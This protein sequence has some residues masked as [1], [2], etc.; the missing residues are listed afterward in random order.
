MTARIVL[1]VALFAIAMD[2]RGADVPAGCVPADIGMSSRDCLF[3]ALQLATRNQQLSDDISA[4]YWAYQESLHSSPLWYNNGSPARRAHLRALAR[5][6]MVHYRM[7][8]MREMMAGHLSHSDYVR[9]VTLFWAL[10]V[11]LQ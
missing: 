7:D 10:M 5:H 3:R 6:R 11:E 9:S 1:A 2:G 4:G 8:L